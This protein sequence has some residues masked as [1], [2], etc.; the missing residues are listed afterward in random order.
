MMSQAVPK[1]KNDNNPNLA[2]ALLSCID[3]TGNEKWLR[4]LFE[5][6]LSD[7]TLDMKLKLEIL[8]KLMT[9]EHVP[10]AVR[11]EYRNWRFLADRDKIPDLARDESPLIQSIVE[12]IHKGSSSL[13]D[14]GSKIREMKASFKNP[15]TVDDYLKKECLPIS[16]NTASKMDRVQIIVTPKN[17]F[18]TWTSRVR[19]DGHKAGREFTLTIDPVESPLTEE[20]LRIMKEKNDY[21][22]YRMAMS[23]VG[24]TLVSHG[25]VSVFVELALPD[26]SP[27]AKKSQPCQL[28]Q[29]TTPCKA[30]DVF[31]TIYDIYDHTK[32]QLAV[33]QKNGTRV[34]GDLIKVGE[35]RNLPEFFPKDEESKKAQAFRIID[36]KVIS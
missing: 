14:F 36:T 13:E 2:N 32:L 21:G 20:F 26:D 3:E 4:Y 33:V 19:A 17:P 23:F 24:K 16:D 28:G 34:R 12:F 1:T 35:I 18:A 11:K 29:F 6:T 31:L 7:V 15:M 9:L 8:D 27:L 22:H 5:K 25:N 10:L 30:G